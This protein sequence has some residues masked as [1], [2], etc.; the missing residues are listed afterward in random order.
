MSTTKELD[1]KIKAVHAKIEC[2][3]GRAIAP[4]ARASSSRV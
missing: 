4:R 3:L 1:A 2:V